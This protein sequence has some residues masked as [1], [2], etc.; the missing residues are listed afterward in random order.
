MTDTAVLLLTQIAVDGTLDKHG[1]DRQSL[2]REP[3]CFQLPVTPKASEG[4]RQGHRLPASP[5]D[6]PASVAL[7]AVCHRTN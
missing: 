1:E 7:Q 6:G 5:K 3:V 4:A 2:L